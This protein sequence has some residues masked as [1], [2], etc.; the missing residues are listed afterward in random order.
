MTTTF[1]ASSLPLLSQFIKLVL[2]I[3]P[4]FAECTLLLLSIIFSAEEKDLQHDNIVKTN[5]VWCY[6]WNYTVLKLALYISTLISLMLILHWIYSR[7]ILTSTVWL[8]CCL[9][10]IC[11]Q[12]LALTQRKL[13]DIVSLTQNIINIIF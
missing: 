5:N 6:E 11:S 10:R 7:K 2:C 1:C 12:Y 4:P 9:C 8:L 13:H 3:T